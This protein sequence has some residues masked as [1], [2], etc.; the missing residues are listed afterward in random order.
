[1]DTA[2]NLDLR[3]RA[4]APHELHEGDTIEMRDRTLEVHFRPGHSPSDTVFYDARRRHLI[5]AD[6]SSAQMEPYSRPQC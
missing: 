3:L 5:A 4:G 6:H 1:M 2:I